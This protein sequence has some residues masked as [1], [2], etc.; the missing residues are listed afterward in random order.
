M[1]IRDRTLIYVIDT[2]SG[3]VV[4]HLNLQE[5]AAPEFIISIEHVLNGIAWKQETET[6]WVTGKNWQR[7]YELKL[8]EHE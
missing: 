2:E 7:L 3:Q 8:L 4:S 6:L 5:L 1:C